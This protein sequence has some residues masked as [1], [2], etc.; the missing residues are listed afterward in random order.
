MFYLVAH[1][2]LN[3]NDLLSYL[4]RSD[5]RFFSKKESQFE[6][7]TVFLDF[8]KNQLPGAKTTE[9]RIELFSKL[10]NKLLPLVN[11]PQEKIYFKYFDFISW[12][13]SKIQGQSFQDILQKKNKE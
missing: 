4:I 8:L 7:E 6:L 11:H 5:S 10:R 9:H 12:L 13:E 1:Y 3:N 2:E